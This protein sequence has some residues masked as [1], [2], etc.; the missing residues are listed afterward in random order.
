[1]L[2]KNIYKTLA[3][4]GRKTTALLPA[5]LESPM[6]TPGEMSFLLKRRNYHHVTQI[7]KILIFLPYQLYKIM[8]PEETID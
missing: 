8:F 7:T 5:S 4:L 3:E 6:F 1:M 2:Y